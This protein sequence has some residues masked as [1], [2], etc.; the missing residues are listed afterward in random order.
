MIDELPEK[1]IYDIVK[2]YPAIFSEISSF[3]VNNSDQFS[4]Y[5]DTT[6]E[7]ILLMVK[8]AITS[9]LQEHDVDV[10]ITMANFDKVD[11]TKTAAGNANVSVNISHKYAKDDASVSLPTIIIPSP[12]FEPV[13]L[14]YLSQTNLYMNRPAKEQIVSVSSMA[15]YPKETLYV[16]VEFIDDEGIHITTRIKSVNWS[17]YSV[18]WKRIIFEDGNVFGYPTINNSGERL[19][20]NCTKLEFIDFGVPAAG[21]RIFS[22]Q[23]AFNGCESLE[24][25]DLRAL[26][27]SQCTTAKWAFGYCKKLKQVLVTKGKWLPDTCDTTYMWGNGSSAASISSVTFA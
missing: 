8:D 25:L 13:P 6:D 17:A 10:D 12:G 15:G 21:S 24:V 7:E 18:P 5:N 2:D 11:A 20:Y 19:F 23:D 9:I 1:E 4:C 16:P 14:K 3:I 22:L 26:D 27:F